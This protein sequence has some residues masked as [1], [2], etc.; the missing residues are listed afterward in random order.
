M[1]GFGET[2]LLS[3]GKLGMKGK[4][5][6]CGARWSTST[7]ERSREIAIRSYTGFPHVLQAQV[8]QFGK[9]F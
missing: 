2:S 4:K 7:E 1:D 6:S 8:P 5:T 3:R 9:P